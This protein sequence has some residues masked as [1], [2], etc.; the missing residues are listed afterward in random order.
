[1]KI[2]LL[3]VESIGW[4]LIKPE[5]SVYED[6]DEK[7]VSVKDA[8]VMMLSVESDDDKGVAEKAVADVTKIMK[9]LKRSRLVIYPYAH[10]SNDLADPKSAMQIIDSVYKAVGSEGIE[11][12]KARS[13]GTR[14]GA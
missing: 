13:G 3:D 2:L 10:L 9:Q 14:N 4:E 8:L 5:A 12:R 6:T 11:V 1:M 7:S